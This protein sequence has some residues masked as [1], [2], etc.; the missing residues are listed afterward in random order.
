MAKQTKITVNLQGLE[1]FKTK[2]GK[3]YKARVGIL[4]S[5]AAESHGDGIDNATLG[6]IQMF[7][8]ITNHIPPRDFLVM[9]IERNKREILKTMNSQSVRNAFEAGDYKKVFSLL[10]ASAVDYVQQAFESGGFGQWPPHA[11]STVAKYGAHALLILSGQLRRAIT[12][13]VVK[14]GEKN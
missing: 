2:I 8:S 12:N 13:D 4:G 7:G 14:K 1:D 11:P 9:P 3:S 5:K 10:G 6:V